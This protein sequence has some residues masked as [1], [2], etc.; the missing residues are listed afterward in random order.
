MSALS[1]VAVDN[2]KHIGERG[3]TAAPVCRIIPGNTIAI[4][5]MAD[6]GA[7]VMYGNMNRATRSAQELRLVLNLVRPRYFVPIHG[8]YRRWINTRGWPST[9]AIRAWKRRS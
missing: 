2:H 8:E 7:D 5:R 9:C 1:R 3:D 4:Y 6:H